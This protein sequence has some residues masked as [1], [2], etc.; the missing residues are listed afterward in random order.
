[1]APLF[2][3]GARPDVSCLYTRHRVGRSYPL[4]RQGRFAPL[5]RHLFATEVGSPVRFGTNRLTGHTQIQG[6]KGL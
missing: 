4:Q 3:H 6:S 2:Q 1:M 5:W